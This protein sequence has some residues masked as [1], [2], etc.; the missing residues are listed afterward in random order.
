MTLVQHRNDADNHDERPGAD[1]SLC[2]DWLGFARYL[3]DAVTSGDVTVEAA[4]RELASADLGITE[5]Q[6]IRRAAALAQTQLGPTSL[7]TALLRGAA[8]GLPS[9]G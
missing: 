3:A 6:A 9:G 2:D 4:G 8:E 1:D 5:R 7:V